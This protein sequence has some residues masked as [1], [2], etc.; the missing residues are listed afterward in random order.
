MVS[1][2]IYNTP[3]AGASAGLPGSFTDDSTSAS[4]GTSDCE[5]GGIHVSFILLLQVAQSQHAYVRIFRS[6][7]SFTVSC[8][9]EPIFGSEPP[10]SER[11]HLSRT[12][13][14]RARTSSSYPSYMNESASRAK[15]F[16]EPRTKLTQYVSTHR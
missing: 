9:Y 3:E 14:H 8:R 1:C 7:S 12:C 15:R 10:Y 6:C 4:E 5:A 13:F 16:S 11:L 2:P